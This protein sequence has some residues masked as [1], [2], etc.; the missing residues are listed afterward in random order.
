AQDVTQDIFTNLW[1]KRHELQIDN[2]PAYLH[3]AVRNKVL[4][5]FEKERRY[6]PLEKLL[7]ENLR[8]G[9]QADAVALRNEFMQAYNTLVDALPMQRKRIFQY[10]FD[11]GLS[12]GE[13]AQRM[14]LSRKTV[15][16]QLGKAILSV[17]TK[18]S[19]LLFLL[20]IL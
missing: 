2:L 12:T 18:L 19:H 3:T 1:L 11:Q 7:I 5:L 4:N 20:M 16:N 15:Q 8:M 10:H 14:S 13:I 17:K 6:I 9:E